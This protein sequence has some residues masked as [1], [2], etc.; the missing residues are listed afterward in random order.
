MRGPFSSAILRQHRQHSL[1]ARLPILL[2]GLTA[3]A[4]RDILFHINAGERF[5]GQTFESLRDYLMRL[6]AIIRALEIVSEPSRR[7]SDELKAPY[8][9]VPWREMAAAGNFYRTTMKT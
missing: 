5:E 9:D 2:T 3:A 7:L 8:P 6:Y 1:Q 4:L